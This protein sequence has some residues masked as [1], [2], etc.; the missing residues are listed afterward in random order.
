[1]PLV[2]KLLK[3]QESNL[4]NDPPVCWRRHC[5]VPVPKGSYQ[6]Q[7]FIYYGSVIITLT[8]GNNMFVKI[9]V[10]LPVFPLLFK[11]LVLSE[12]SVMVRHSTNPPR[13]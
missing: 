2:Y 3:I 5:W 6:S 9:R 13:L 1:M 11:N 8:V 7:V 10:N 12:N 4:E